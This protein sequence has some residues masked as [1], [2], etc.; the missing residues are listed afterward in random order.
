M[1]KFFSETMSKFWITIMEKLNMDNENILTD[2]LKEL[3]Q[4]FGF[5]CSFIYM[6][7]N[8]GNFILHDYYKSYKGYDHLGDMIHLKENLSEELYQQLAQEKYV[9]FDMRNRHSKL[10]SVIAKLFRANAMV[11][12]PVTE[13][14]T[15]IQALIGMVDRRGKARE[16]DQD[17]RFA[18]TVLSVIANHM[19]I[20]LSRQRSEATMYMLE[21][22][23]DHT[24]VD[25]YVA[26]FDTHEILYANQSMADRYGGMDQLVGKKCWAT[27][28]EDEEGTC[29]F[30]PKHK[31]VDE[32]KKPTEVHIWSQ[33]NKRDD[34]W[35]RMLSSAFYWIDGRLAIVGSNVDIT[36]NKKNEEKIR[37]HAEYDALTG[38]ANRHK[39][40]LDCDDGIEKLKRENREGYLVFCDL[41]KFKQVNDTLGHQAGDELLKLIGQFFKENEHT[42]NRTYR[43]GGDEFIILCFDHT[44]EEVTALVEHFNREFK[45]LWKLQAGEVYCGISAGITRYPLDALTTSDLL[46]SAD[47]AMYEAKLK[48]R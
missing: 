35:R 17:V 38:L 43:Y 27:I 23:L 48:S 15:E 28:F 46:H 8:K 14:E 13:K 24:G 1:K 18:Y 7:D 39:L 22:V 42:S 34:S 20:L 11:L 44:Y 19:K 5:G 26:D 21:S 6:G 37:Y 29:A 36:E 9:S 32:N 2:V 10:D 3:C 33:Y 25:V 40:L 30:C 4:Y 16:G 12:I 31:L 41:N 47:K 45:K